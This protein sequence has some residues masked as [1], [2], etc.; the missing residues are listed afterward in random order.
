MPKRA[1]NLPVSNESQGSKRNKNGNGQGG[2]LQTAS[3]S[4]SFRLS[5]PDPLTGKPVRLSKSGFRT[6]TEATKALSKAIAEREKG[7]LA[8]PNGVT[9]DDWFERF[10][11]SKSRLADK[12]RT[13]YR[14]LFKL[15]V[16]PVLGAVKVQDLT[17]ARLQGLYATLR[18]KA[19][20]RAGEPLSA[21]TQTYIFALV[22]ALLEH[23]VRL[24]VVGRNVAD[25]AKPD[26]G[27]LDPTAKVGQAWTLEEAA[28]FL[29]AARLEP[30]HPVFYLLL[31]CGLRRGEA[32]GLRWENVNLS[33]LSLKVT[34][35]LVTVSGRA[36]PSKPKTV[37]SV[38]VVAF[39]PDT[40][41]VLE[42]HRA[43]QEAWNANMGL[44][45]ER[46]WVFTSL[47][48]TPIHPDNLGRT[49]DRIAKRAGIR[50][51]RVH[52]L[53][54]TFTSLARRQGVPVEVV[55]RLL[56]HSRTSFTLTEYR[57]VYADEVQA[58]AIDLT[59]ILNAARPTAAA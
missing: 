25:V 6:K 45:P 5:L 46:D 15:H 9:L 29:D 26:I 32:L 51:V 28:A 52:D 18:V 11:A 53:R 1:K 44:T 20:P 24:E 41:A 14:G 27:R 3:G 43:R 36:V 42:A 7:L 37:N 34:E 21:R 13:S 47:N 58:A 39:T 35:T 31:A 33:G 55:S 50:R 12:T 48:G 22:H 17:P 59:G 4:W 30:L 40:A 16:S 54:H 2:V 38:R 8:A 23:A 19:G 57:H 49:L 10:M 56:G